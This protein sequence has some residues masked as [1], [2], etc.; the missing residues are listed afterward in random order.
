MFEKAIERGGLKVRRYKAPL[1][2]VPKNTWDG[3]VYIHGV[4]EKK[5][6]ID[7]LSQLVL[8]SRDFG[9]AYLTERWA[10]RF[11]SELF[12]SFTVCFVGYSI[13]DPVNRYMTDALAADRESG[14]GSPEMFA[15]GGYSNEESDARKNEWLEKPV[16]PI[17]YEDSC[18]HE[19]LHKTLKVWSEVYRD[20]TRGKEGIVAEYAASRPTGSTVEDKA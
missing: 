9:L 7:E 20:G 16:T 11:V 8:A 6:T 5:P 17:L 4:L 2:P 10:A 1:L 13:S 19:K 15:F 3:I 12:R 14:E 18:N